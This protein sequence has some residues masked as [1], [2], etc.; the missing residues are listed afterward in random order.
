MRLAGLVHESITD[1]PGIRLAVFVQG[2]P[3][4]CPGCH[5]PETHD[6]RGGRDITVV[7]IIRIYDDNPLL[8]GVTLSGG[9]PFEQAA[10]LVPL[11]RAIRE[12]GGNVISYSGYTYEQLLKRAEA[13]P[14]ITDLLRASDWLIDGPFVL[15]LRDL[16][17]LFRGSSN[18]RILKLEPDGVGIVS[19]DGFE[20]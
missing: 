1:G 3:H 20:N 11:A 16:T 4:N 5:N 6:P 13:D 18:Q 19:R 2:C 7:E 15:A 12:R 9:E 8:S 17:L 10:A 14:A